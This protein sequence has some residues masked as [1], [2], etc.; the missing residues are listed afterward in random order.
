MALHER[1]S[2]AKVELKDA[3]LRAWRAE[4]VER[5]TEVTDI[6]AP[7][8]LVRALPSGK[9]T[10]A[11]RMRKPGAEPGSHPQGRVIGTYPDIGLKEARDEAERLRRELREGRD[12]TVA[13]ERVACSSAAEKARRMP[14]LREVLDEYEAGPGSRLSSWKR[15][16][17][18]GRSDAKRRIELVFAPLLDMRVTEISAD[19]LAGTMS[20]YQPASG[21][22]SANGQVQR[23]RAY[24]APVFDWCAAR[25]RYRRAGR[26]RPAPLDVCDVRDTHDPAT[27]DPTI[28]RKRSR[29]LNHTELAKI[30]PL[31]VWP[32]P[33]CLKLGIPPEQDTRPLALRFLLLTCAR[34]EELVRMRWRDF[35]EET[36]VW[37]KPRVK[38]PSGPPRQQ[39]LP[40]SDAA[41]ALLKG[42]PNYPDRRPDDLVFP[43]SEGG[44]LGN[45][46]RFTLPI[47]RESGTS[48]WHR[49]DLRRTGA[50]FMKVLR[51]APRTIDEIL[52]HNAS[53]ED[54]G[55]S[56]ALENY[57]SEDNVLEHIEHPQKE[58][59]DTLAKALAHIERKDAG[60]AAAPAGAA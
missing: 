28:T 55:T 9:V 2:M 47:Q 50:T 5:R 30:L 8:L 49:H 53:R 60:N 17:K 20:S 18:S 43:N 15:R 24:L 41:I 10:F 59:L 1:D 35:R 40:L 32:A 16:P 25:E 22:A 42:L 27:D 45:W 14:T 46:H 11:F 34:R 38:T 36:G 51:V 23:A 3:H 44:F 4:P 19:A 57:F 6:K 56:L 33:E 26:G 29:A 21:V 12:I 13:A 58:A 31:L 52:A 7:G 54:E 48:G 37:H 39:S